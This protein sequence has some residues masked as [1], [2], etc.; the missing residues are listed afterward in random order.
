MNCEEIRR[1]WHL[2]HDSEGESE[3]HWTISQH[4]DNCA[5]CAEWF[6]KQSRFEDL[7]S[8]KLRNVSSEE[9]LW[10]SVLA[11]T[12]LSRPVPSRRW[13]MFSSLAACAAVVLI[14]LGG[15]LLQSDKHDAA[16]NLPQLTASWHERLATG[17]LQAPFQSA[18]DLDVENYLVHEVSFPVRCPPRKDSGFAVRGAG[19]CKLG[20][21]AAAY[22]VGDVDDTPVSL[23]ILARESLAAFPQQEA[24]L[25]HEAVHRC[26]EGGQQMAVSIIDQ[27]LVL[28][29]G[30]V[31]QERLTRVLRAYGTYPHRS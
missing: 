3:I 20:Q 16:Q 15:S 19:T 11:N 21:Q 24:E 9:H 22:V 4:L 17:D 1:H 28:V 31:P 5:P 23:F 27:N 30:Q 26:H 10:Q 6:S 7:L 29:V 13:F 2:Y 25:L 8:E 12:G 18:S 14:L